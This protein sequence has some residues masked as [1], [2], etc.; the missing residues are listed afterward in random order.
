MY[1]INGSQFGG[2]MGWSLNTDADPNDYISSY[3]PNAPTSY[4]ADYIASQ[5]QLDI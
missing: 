1:G 5:I 4:F 3:A 2:L